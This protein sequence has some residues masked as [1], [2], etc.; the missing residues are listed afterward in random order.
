MNSILQ[1]INF[2]LAMTGFGVTPNPTPPTADAALIYAIPEADVIV[3]FDAVSVVPGNFKA[4]KALPDMPEIKAAKELRDAAKKIVTDV[5][6]GRALIKGMVGLDLTT[7][8][9]DVTAFVQRGVVMDKPN[10]LAA[11]HG[12]FDVASISKLAKMTQGVV[13]PGGNL[14]E[15][16]GKVAVGL[17]KSGVL[18]VG[19]P[20]LVKP[21]LADSWRAP[22]RNNNALLTQAA[23]VINGKPFFAVMAALAPATRKQI[24]GEIG[25]NFLTDVV[26]RHKFMA[27]SLYADGI[28]WVWADTSKPGLDRMIMMSEGLIEVMRAAQVA[29]RGIGK[30]MLAALESYRGKSRELDQLIAAKSKIANAI[31]AYTGDGLFQVS[32]VVDAKNLRV[33]VR[34]TGKTLSEVVPAALF[35][36]AIAWG[37]FT[38]ASNGAPPAIIMEQAAPPA[39]PPAPPARRPSPPRRK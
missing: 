5:D 21:R 3:H 31:T 11:V 30:I 6:G 14:V 25:E 27:L 18:L 32:Q 39:R 23:D 20:S 10:V 24:A 16:E 22:T 26:M 4:L 36:P 28:G 33:T 8:V 19:T 1:V 13:A 35:V 37:M 12:K 9:H 29:P 34:A 38:Q 7:D 15:I 2:L 17:T